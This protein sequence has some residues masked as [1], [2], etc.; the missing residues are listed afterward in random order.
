MSPLRVLVGQVK[1]LRRDE[2]GKLVGLLAATAIGFFVNMYAS[3]HYARWDVT[4]DRRYTLSAATKTTLREL[5]EPVEV[6]VLLGAQEPLKQSVS[7]ILTAYA[8]ESS[9]I[10]V[11]NVDPDKDPLA[12]EDVR[13]RFRIEA[14]RAE[15]GRVVTDAAIV[16]ARREKHWFIEPTDLYTA[17]EKDDTKVRPREEEALTLAIRNVVREGARARL[18]FTEG[19]GEASTRDGSERGLFFLKNVLEKD[20]YDVASV[21]LTAP[22]SGE[23]FAGCAVVI[24]PGPRSAFAA[25]EA[26]RLR[27]YLMTGGSGLFALGP[28]PD[29]AGV[30]PT[31]LSSVLAP[32][33]VRLGGTIVVEAAKDRALPDSYGVRFFADPKPHATTMG[34]VVRDEREPPRV[35]VQLSRPL[36]H[37][38]EAGA[39]VATDL[40]VSS[41]ESFG[42]ATADG[43]ATWTKTPEKRPEDTSGPFVLAMAAEREKTHRDAPHG[44]RVVVLG[45]STALFEANFREPFGVRGA[46]LL[47]E[48]SLSW[49]ATK[50]EIVDIPPKADVAAGVRITEE[51]RAEVRRYVV[52]LMPLAVALLGV[53][54]AFRRKS[55][56]GRA[57]VARAPVEGTPAK[58]EGRR[59]DEKRAGR[60]K[61]GRPGR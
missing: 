5:R 9:Q 61:G 57:H 43:A 40:L 17:S 46:A 8:A 7:Q 56:E 53:A 37:A 54:V 2:L 47:V 26:E 44:P 45:A 13:K 21:D 19:H 52:F 55:T 23:P 48:S 15:D 29:A 60:A 42:I 11:K 31:G 30:D 59:S 58:R 10:V 1:A 28:T 18:C 16:V 35:L 51:S 3:R 25:G 38:T 49:L 32:F 27:T 20:N 4:E 22:G 33:G 12:F 24:V 50:P 36:Y 14:G 39:A 6:W 41:P 34:L